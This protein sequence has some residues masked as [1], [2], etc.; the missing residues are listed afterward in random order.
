MID[1]D[2]VTLAHGHPVFE[3]EQ[4]IHMDVHKRH[5]RVY[6]NSQDVKF[7]LAW[8]ILPISSVQSFE[9]AQKEKYDDEWPKRITNEEYFE[10]L[11][12]KL[13]NCPDVVMPR[14]E[15]RSLTGSLAK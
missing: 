2:A 10:R 7:N 9:E 13:E 11:R 15:C 3:T 8:G 12:T 1:L 6:L 4:E 14:E 5:V